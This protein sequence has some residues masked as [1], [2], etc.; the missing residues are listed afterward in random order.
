MSAALIAGMAIKRV[1]DK[2]VTIVKTVT[3]GVKA[4]A[5]WLGEKKDALWEKIKPIA[6]WFKEKGD[7][8]K[9]WWT[10]TAKPWI[11]DAKAKLGAVFDTLLEFYNNNIKPIVD[12]FKGL[13]DDP[14]SVGEVFGALWTFWDETIKPKIIDVWDNF[15][16]GAVDIIGKFAGKIEDVPIIGNLFTFWKAF[17][18][19]AVKVGLKDKFAGAIEKIPL[20]G[21]LITFWNAF[22]NPAVKVALKEKF[23]E[24]LENLPLIGPLIKFWNRFQSLE[25]KDKI[26]LMDK[27]VGKLED[28]PVIGGLIT[29]WKEFTEA[30]ISIGELFSG[31]IPAPL[32]SIMDFFAGVLGI[33]EENE[34]ILDKL[35]DVIG[36]LFDTIK[37]PVNDFI[38]T[39]L[40][41]LMGYELPAIGKLQDISI[42]SSMFPIPE[43]AE[44]GIVNSPTLALIGEA[45]PEAVVPLNSQGRGMGGGNQTFNMTFNLSGITD[46]TDKRKLAQDVSQMLRTELRRTVGST[47]VRGGL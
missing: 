23:T 29:W 47:S 20:I 14:P 15:K 26:K 37:G 16:E 28:L 21:A 11:D 27:F 43:L 36:A 31:M 12:W 4:F 17:K 34:G 2:I 38:I 3:K 25:D 45:G 46:R 7:A 13:K 40:N 22:K 5:K 39:P 24:V 18:D 44:G 42:L 35:G 30:D 33:G 19:P 8:I 32:Q 6:D 1:G 41:A 9:T 10:E